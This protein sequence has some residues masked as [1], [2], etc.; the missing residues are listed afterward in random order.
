MRAWR[1][2]ETDFGPHGESWSQLKFR[3][4]S[5]VNSLFEERGDECWDAGYLGWPNTL[6]C[7]GSPAW[8]VR[9][10]SAPSRQLLPLASLLL[11]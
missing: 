2:S 10:N 6:L 1:L 8:V 9:Q 3:A 7:N 5:G 4:A 11:V